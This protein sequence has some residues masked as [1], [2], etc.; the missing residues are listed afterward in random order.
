MYKCF[1]ASFT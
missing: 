1:S